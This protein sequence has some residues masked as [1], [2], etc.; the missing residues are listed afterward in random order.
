MRRCEA[1]RDGSTEIQSNDGRARHAQSGQ[2]AIQVL[3]LGCNPIVG[4]EGTVGR[5]VAEHV[6]GEGR[7]IRERDRRP[8]IAPHEAVG[9]ETVHQ[10]H[11]LTAKTIAFYVKRARSDGHAQEISVDGNSPVILIVAGA[12]A[13][14]LGWPA[15]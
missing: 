7:E 5:A 13:N 10:Q 3:R 14:D 6:H 4:V 1:K 11:G 12:A 9:A 8:D 15:M 2:S